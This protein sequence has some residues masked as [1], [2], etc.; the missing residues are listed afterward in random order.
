MTFGGAPA[1]LLMVWLN[2]IIGT[3]TLH[4]RTLFRGMLRE[5]RD[6][7]LTVGTYTVFDGNGQQVMTGSLNDPRSPLELPAGSYR[8]VFT[9]SNYW[10]RNARGTVTLSSEFTLV[11]GVP[12]HDQSTVAQD[13]KW[14]GP[15]PA[16]MV[17]GD[18]MMGNGMK[19]N[20]K[21][22]LGGKQ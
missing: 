13:A 2:H 14:T 10:L 16:D 6:N 20:I 19:M 11:P 3:N 15:C 1:H 22:M 18:V 5:E 4:F 12:G 8:T 7:D 21:Q 17:A 9:S